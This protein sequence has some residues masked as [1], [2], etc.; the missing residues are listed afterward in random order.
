MPTVSTA[1]DHNGLAQ[2]LKEVFSQLGKTQNP[3]YLQADIDLTDKQAVENADRERY[4]FVD[5]VV[6]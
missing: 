5:Q 2:V 4:H 6:D 3:P 1:K